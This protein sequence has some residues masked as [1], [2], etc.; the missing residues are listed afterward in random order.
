MTV[1]VPRRLSAGGPNVFPTKTVDVKCPAQRLVDLVIHLNDSHHW[2]REQIA[3]WLDTL[4]ADLRFGTEAPEVPAGEYAHG[5]VELLDHTAGWGEP[6]L[7]NW[8]NIWLP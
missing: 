8:K 3:D 1:G 6:A 7:L 2:S 4:D 5:V